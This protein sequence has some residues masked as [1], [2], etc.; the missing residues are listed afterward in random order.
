MNPTKS[1][2]EKNDENIVII[3][4][5]GV[6]KAYLEEF[7]RVSVQPQL[8]LTTVSIE[9]QTPPCFLWRSESQSQSQSVP[10]SAETSLR[11]VSDY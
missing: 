10:V 11:L 6:A 8:S 3:H 5:S 4:D 9:S 2:N 7:E 1:G